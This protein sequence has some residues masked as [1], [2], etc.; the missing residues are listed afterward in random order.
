M[1]IA[2]NFQTQLF[3]VTWMVSKQQIFFCFPWLRL[4]SVLDFNSLSLAR[5]GMMVSE[6]S[7]KNLRNKQFKKCS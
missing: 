4:R 6:I 1:K 7:E 5:R 2:E 3:S